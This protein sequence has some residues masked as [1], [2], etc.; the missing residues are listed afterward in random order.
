MQH[1]WVWT[2]QQTQ[3][4]PLELTHELKVSR[5]N[6]AGGLRP[7][8]RLREGVVEEGVLDVELVHGQM[9]GDSQSQHSLDGDRLDDGAKGFI[10]VYPRALSETRRTM[11]LKIH[12]P[13]MT[14][15]LKIHLPVTT[16]S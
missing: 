7:V 6:D 10:V 11:C 16:L 13:M 2:R 4:N 5:V 1:T 3:H 15:C 9:P 8:D 12:L 14:L